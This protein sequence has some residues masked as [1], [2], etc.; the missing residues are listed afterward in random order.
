MNSKQ[1]VMVL[2]DLAVVIVGAR[3]LGAVAERLRQ[4]AVIGE[5]TFG[6]LAGP[7]LFHG[8]VSRALFPVDVRPALGVLANIGVA[9]FMFVVG[10]EIEGAQLRRAKRVTTAVAVG[11]T[12]VPFALGVLVA[13]LVAGGHVTKN[14]TGFVLFMGLAMSVTAFPVLARILADRDLGRTYIGSVALSAAAVCDIVAWSLLAVVSVISGVASGSAWWV[15]LLFPYVAVMVLVVRPLL[16]R[17]LA[18]AGSPS[19]GTMATLFGGLL[20]SAAC[21]EAMGLHFIFGAFLFGAVVPRD[22]HARLRD[23]VVANVT[24]V[25]RSLLLPVY[26]VVAGLSVDLGALGGSG[27]GELVLIF[28]AATAGKLGGT[29]LGA[30]SRRLPRR[31]ALALAG[32]MNTRGLTELVVLGIGLRAGLLDGG[33]YSM[34]TVMAVV[35]TAMTGPLLGLVYRRPEDS[36]WLPA[37]AAVARR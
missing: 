20:V 32:L 15:L 9:L 30:R 29:Y 17:A 8:A 13:V 22:A 23:A 4:P 1:I 35:T 7:T 12:A 21:T 31:Q 6:V 28:L 3:L 18:G 16:K 11:A 10:L 26:F 34:M 14:P 25:G 33:L 24:V 2:I 36:R 37:E 27:A 5:I 19:P